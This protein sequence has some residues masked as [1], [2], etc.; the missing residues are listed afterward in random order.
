MTTLTTIPTQ[1]TVLPYVQVRTKA[2]FSLESE[3]FLFAKT[4]R[5]LSGLRHYLMPPP[6]SGDVAPT[7]AHRGR[8]ALRGAA[9]VRGDVETN[10]RDVEDAVPYGW[11]QNLPTSN[12]QHASK[13]GVR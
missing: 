7:P 1:Y 5:N 13:R 3:G 10:P 8:C 6:T 9:W 4:K 2:V 11:V 12:T